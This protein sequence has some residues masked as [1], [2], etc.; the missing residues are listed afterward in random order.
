M[1]L[2][3]AQRRLAQVDRVQHGR[4]VAFRREAVCIQ[5]QTL[6]AQGTL[7]GDCRSC[8]AEGGE[9]AEP[10]SF[11][12]T[13]GPHVSPTPKPE[14]LP[15]RR[16]PIPPPRPAEARSLQVVTI[17]LWPPAASLPSSSSP[18]LRGNSYEER[19]E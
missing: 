13:V 11:G 4:L 15:Q 7:R 5:V 16:R 8:E 19:T 14:H 3:V 1:A 17:A 9:G 2:P 6:L 12:V 10:P 18:V